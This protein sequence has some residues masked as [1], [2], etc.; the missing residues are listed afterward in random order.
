MI[1]KKIVSGSLS[2]ASV[3][4][5]GNWSGAIA[6]ISNRHLS[7]QEIRSLESQFQKASQGVT[8][9]GYTDRRQSSEVAQINSFVNAWQKV[10]ST[11]APFLGSWEGLE[12]G[13]S[14]YPSTSNGKVCV[15]Y[16]SYGTDGIQS[17]FN[18]GTISGNKLISDGE[19]GK[20]VIL[21]KTAPVRSGGTSTFL[22]SFQSFRERGIVRAY[23]FP[24][25]VRELRDRRFTRLGCIASLPSTSQPQAST[26]KHPAQAVVSDFYTWYLNNSNTY[27]RVLSQQRDSFTPELYRNLDRAIRISETPR[28]SGMLNFDVFSNAQVES[29]SFQIDSVVP[30]ENSA[31]VYVTLQTG[32]GYNRRR[33]NPIKVLVSKNNNRW[34]IA[35]FVY[36]RESPNIYSLMSILRGIN[37]RQ[38]FNGIP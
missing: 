16:S 5:F 20:T 32:L 23:V 37:Q 19:T 13:L 36:L 14:I 17:S 9:R 7:D 29:Y 4:I 27:R 10:D 21:R 12:E 11:I 6:Q 28:W 30:K 22:A 18:L 31:E 33:P 15:I 35:D 2:F 8:G 38:E 34:Q 1:T 26:Q 25:M 24:K 3:L